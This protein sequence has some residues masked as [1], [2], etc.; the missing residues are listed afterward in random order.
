MNLNNE[1]QQKDKQIRNSKSINKEYSIE[2]IL[3]LIKIY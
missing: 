1:F 3:G 2:Q